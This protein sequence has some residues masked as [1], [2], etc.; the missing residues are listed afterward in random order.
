[1]DNTLPTYLCPFGTFF[2]APKELLKNRQ[3][4]LRTA[5]AQDTLGPTEVHGH[6]MEHPRK[7][8][9]LDRRA[10]PHL[11][12]VQD[13]GFGVKGVGYEMKGVGWRD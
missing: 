1:M 8:V 2:I 6:A 9:A 7:N 13:L 4:K 12:S 10:R 5:C 3:T 11:V